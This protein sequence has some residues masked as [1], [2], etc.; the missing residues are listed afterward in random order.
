MSVMVQIMKLKE[1]A[2]IRDLELGDVIVPRDLSL[3]EL[4][5]VDRHTADRRVGGKGPSCARFM[6]YFMWGG[7]ATFL[8]PDWAI[9]QRDLVAR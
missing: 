6:C 2:G 4:W 9:P 5:H 1:R 7:G 8:S 3:E